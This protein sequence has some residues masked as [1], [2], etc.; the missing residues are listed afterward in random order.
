M[1]V[2]FSPPILLP[3]C[4]NHSGRCIYTHASGVIPAHLHYILAAVPYRCG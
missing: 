1:T 4:S 3:P 2:G